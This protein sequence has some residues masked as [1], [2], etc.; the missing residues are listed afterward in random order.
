MLSGVIVNHYAPFEGD[1]DRQQ[2]SLQR[3]YAPFE[4]T[5]RWRGS[6]EDATDDVVRQV[7][8]SN[9]YLRAQDGQAR[10][11][12]RQNSISDPIPTAET[13][14]PAACATGDRARAVPYPQSIVVTNDPLHPLSLWERGGREG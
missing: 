4:G 12:T 6:L 2:E 7:I 3:S 14:E 1:T 13:R 9:S 11:G 8:R 5:N 10:S